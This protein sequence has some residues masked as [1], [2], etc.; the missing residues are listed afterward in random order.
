MW[1][2][3]IIDEIHGDISAEVWA[4]KFNSDAKAFPGEDLE[5]QKRQNLM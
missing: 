3:P 4:A 5:E 1:K 2:D